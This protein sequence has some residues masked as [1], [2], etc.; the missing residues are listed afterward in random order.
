MALVHWTIFEHFEVYSNFGNCRSNDFKSTENIL[1][2]CSVNTF[3][4]LV[5]RSSNF[6][7]FKIYFFSKLLINRD[8]FGTYTW[9]ADTGWPFRRVARFRP[10]FA[11]PFWFADSKFSEKKI[12]MVSFSHWKGFGRRTAAFNSNRSLNESSFCLKFKRL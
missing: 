10:R 11:S 6:R 5:K 9:A 8:H 4:W 3:K 2:V 1:N 7:K 12:S